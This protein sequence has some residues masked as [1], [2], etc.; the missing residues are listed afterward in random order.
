[1]LTCSVLSTDLHEHDSFLSHPPMEGTYETEVDASFE[2]S[3]V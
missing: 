1:M 2:L 3:G